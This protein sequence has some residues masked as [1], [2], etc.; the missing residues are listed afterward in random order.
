VCIRKKRKEQGFK[1]IKI[2]VVYDNNPYSKDL[3]ADWGFACVIE[4][5]DKTILFDTGAD[6][7]ILLDNMNKIGI[8]AS[9]IDSVVISHDH[10]DHIGG[11][12][13]FLN[14]NPNAEILLPASCPESKKICDGI[15]VS[16]EIDGTC[17]EQCLIVETKDCFV[18]ITGCAH[19]GIV[20]MVEKSRDIVGDNSFFVLGGF[21]LFKEPKAL[22]A[23]IV[24][25]LDKIGVVGWG[26]CHCSG[27]VI[28]EYLRRRYKQQYVEVG[29]GK[30]LSF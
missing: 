6:G 15:F 14:K 23:E 12:Q 13:A 24:D 25:E 9:N 18:V 16:G 20:K 4:T 26:P 29:V 21:H 27:D 17:K 11:L 10:Y 19:P 8:N 30:V 7:A 3:K 5:S 2:T 22:I 28:R 1:L